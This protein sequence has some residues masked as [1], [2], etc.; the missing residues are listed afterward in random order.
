L[1]CGEVQLFEAV[2]GFQSCLIFWR[3]TAKE[4]SFAFHFC[5]NICRSFSQGSIIRS[6]WLQFFHLL[7]FLLSCN[8]R[9]LIRLLPGQSFSSNFFM[10]HLFAGPSS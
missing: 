5:R 9:F 8:L 7:I 3:N 4:A 2:E 6:F 10:G 1:H